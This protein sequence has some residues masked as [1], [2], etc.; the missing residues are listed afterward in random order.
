MSQRDILFGTKK[1]PTGGSDD[2]TKIVLFEYC[3]AFIS[4]LQ[5]VVTWLKLFLIF[6]GL[7]SG[8]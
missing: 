4:I 7:V 5:Y 1:K 6:I 2:K 3:I 8:F